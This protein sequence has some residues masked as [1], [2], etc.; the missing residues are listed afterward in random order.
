[1][2]ALDV[3]NEDSINISKSILLYI[4]LGNAYYNISIEI[5]PTIPTCSLILQIGLCIR[6]KLY[7]EID[8]KKYKI[9]L[10][11]APGSHNQEAEGIK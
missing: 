3:I 4:Y 9:I 6:Y 7:K 11:V 8:P 5:K 10:M 1:L 2:E